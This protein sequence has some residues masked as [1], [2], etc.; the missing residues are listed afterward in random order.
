VF[1]RS[2][3]YV[4]RMAD[5]AR[6]AGVGVGTLYNYFESKELIF[7]SLLEDRHR[8]FR[9][10]VQAAAVADDPIERLKQ[11]VESAFAVLGERGE[12]LAVFME[13]GAVGE[14]DVERLVGAN[15][16]RDYGEFLALLEKTIRDAVRAKKMRSDVDVRLLVS[17]LAGAI[18]AAIYGWLER[19]RRGRLSSVTDALFDIFIEGARCR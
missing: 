13:R 7:S 15:A 6:E 4:T 2:G 17:A 18:N 11:I 5:I 16:A 19:G 8:E 1:A 9:R 14:C 12:L 10:T 3:F